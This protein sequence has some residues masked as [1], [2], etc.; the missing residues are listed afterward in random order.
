MI[1]ATF[2]DDTCRMLFSKANEVDEVLM[3]SPICS[4]WVTGEGEYCL[5]YIQTPSSFVK[6]KM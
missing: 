4:S 3:K 2:N 5:E 1:R 6:Y